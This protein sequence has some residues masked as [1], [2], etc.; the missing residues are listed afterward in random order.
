MYFNNVQDVHL[1]I[2]LVA[3]GFEVYIVYFYTVYRTMYRQR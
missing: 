2:S 3:Y 1:S